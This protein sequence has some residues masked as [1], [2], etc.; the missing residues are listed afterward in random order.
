MATVD[1]A[2]VISLTAGLSLFLLSAER[3]S[4]LLAVIAS[5]AT[6]DACVTG[7]DSDVRRSFTYS[8]SGRTFFSKTCSRTTVV[9]QIQSGH[10]TLR[11]VQAF[12]PATWLPNEINIYAPAENLLTY[13]GRPH[14]ID[15]GRRLDMYHYQAGSH[16][17]I[18]AQVFPDN[19]VI[20]SVSVEFQE[21]M[22]NNSFKPRP[23]RGSA[24]W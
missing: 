15:R 22:P 14:K 17:R 18:V 16:Q 2:I 1:R 20:G 13:L 23:L 11:S 5:S 7:T 10:L 3:G 12:E 19:N 6:Q 8:E 4:R 9:W 24:A 21:A